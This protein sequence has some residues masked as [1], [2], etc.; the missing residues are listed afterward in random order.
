M[1][2]KSILIATAILALSSASVFADYKTVDCSTNPAFGAN[3]CW[4]CFD[5]WAKQAWDNLWLLTDDWINNWT[6]DQVFLK[7]ENSDKPTMVNMSESNVTWT[8]T[9]APE[10]FWTYTPELEKL[11]SVDDSWYVL[12][13]WQKVTWLKSKIDA[14]YTLSKNTA[15]EW[16][17]IG[18]LIYPIKVHNMV[19]WAP[20]V[21][22]KEHKECVLF[23]SW[24]ATEKVTPAPKK[25]E[26]KKLPKTW[27]ESILLAFL[28]LIMALSILKFRKKA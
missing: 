28:A 25:V 1:T 20:S 13:A 11:K 10:D 6:A 8:Q 4:Q 27:P 24:K 22:S 14:T 7:E 19:S 26:P 12:P 17:D 3:S 23:K 2:K 15:K 16:T 9:V 21:E 5:W 18:M